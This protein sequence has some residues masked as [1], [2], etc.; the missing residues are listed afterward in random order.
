MYRRNHRS[1][2]A[3][4]LFAAL[5]GIALCG[6]A[7]AD[8]ATA[9]RA[10]SV[11]ASI[12]AAT[13]PVRD[14]SCSLKVIQGGAESREYLE[15]R[16]RMFEI[17]KQQGLDREGKADELI[18]ETRRRLKVPNRAET[19]LETSQWKMNSEGCFHTIQTS[20]D[21]DGKEQV[22]ERGWDGQEMRG[23]DRQSNR[24]W[25]WKTPL[26]NTFTPEFAWTDN[27]CHPFANFL[28]RALE[29]GKIEISDEPDVG[30]EKR[31]KVTAIT[32]PD[33]LGHQRVPMFIRVW[34]NVSRNYVPIR[35][36]QGYPFGRE[37][38]WVVG[39]ITTEIVSKE[40]LPGVWYPVSSKVSGATIGNLVDHDKPAEK[41]KLVA[42]PN[43]YV[44]RCELSNIQV[45]RGLKK[46]DFTIKFREG[47]II[48]GNEGDF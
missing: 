17:L 12:R 48:N 31:L 5:F 45:N 15:N 27:S 4:I 18:A 10:K 11:I 30:G 43:S 36:E 13:R 44:T 46:E 41:W 47:A 19:V 39:T 26:K 40:I 16:I 42:F 20:K 38:D 23:Y 32:P 8:E 28:E 9:K 24:G 7:A 14:W 22:S 25:T 35:I 1:A 3:I 6:H 2:V 29:T 37:A 33:E 21:Q 34:L